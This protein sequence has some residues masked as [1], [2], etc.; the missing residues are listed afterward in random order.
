MTFLNTHRRS[1]TTPVSYAGTWTKYV[2]PI[3]STSKNILAE[4]EGQCHVTAM[5]DTGTE[6]FIYYLGANPTI[7]NATNGF[8]DTDQV[9]LARKT[10]DNN[11]YTG[12]SK[13]VDGSSLPI[14]V[15]TISSNAAHFDRKQIW[16]RTVI[17]EGSTYKGWYIGQSTADQFRVGYATSSDGISWTKYASNPV[18]EDFT[19]LAVGVTGFTIFL[20]ADDSKYKMLYY[21]NE[22]GGNLCMAESTDGIAWTKLR[23][24]ILSTLGLGWANNFAKFSGEY[25]IWAAANVRMF[26]GISKYIWCYKTSD[27]T[28]YENLG[29]QLQYT[30][31]VAYG[32]T[33]GMRIGVKPN[34]SYFAV[35]TSYRNQMHKTSNLGEEFNCINAYDLNRSDLPIGGAVTLSYPAN[36]LRHYSLSPDSFSS[37]TTTERVNGDAGTITSAPSY[38]AIT[39]FGGRTMDFVTF[40]GTQTV[41]FPG[42]TGFNTNVFAVKLRV[43]LTLTGTHELFRIGNDILVTL[44]SGNLRVRLSS[45]GSAYQKDYVSTADIS[46]PNATWIDDHLYVGF[47][48]NNGTLKLYNDFNEFSTTKTVDDAL[49]NVNNS[50]SS[51]LI[52]QNCTVKL[53]S[54]SVMIGQ[55]DQEFID[56]EI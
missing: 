43:S 24:G 1:L 11:V 42:L 26:S 7:T 31:G 19:G 54:I 20:D 21:G 28:T 9:Y 30:D 46:K 53:R 4:D 14:A 41:T 40:S 12:W 27:F 3:I 15:L 32:V 18:Y 51:V 49:T 13:Y 44:E 37:L 34:G 2:Q 6:W 50:G 10:K 8:A 39:A 56:L 33:G 55:T 36:V 52:G 17:K 38:A 29:P 23:S 45:N 5:V 47:T 22:L 16:M 35:L 48:F 25:Y